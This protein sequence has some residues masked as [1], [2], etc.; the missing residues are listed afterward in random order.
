[1]VLCISNRFCF[2]LREAQRPQLSESVI[3]NCISLQA[4]L[5]ENKPM[6][7]AIS[8]N[9]ASSRL[10]RISAMS[11]EGEIIAGKVGS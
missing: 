1:M 11:V 8:V 2:F 7:A 10:M 6:T 3:T 4:L 9:E 5:D